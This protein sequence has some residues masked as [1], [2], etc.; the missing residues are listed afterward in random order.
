MND[1]QIIINKLFRDLVK[2]Y[3]SSKTSIIALQAIIDALDHLECSYDELKDQK[4]I[5]SDQIKNTQPRMFPLDNLMILLDKDSVSHFQ[6][7]DIDST[8]NGVKTLFKS[9]LDRLNDDLVKLT[10]QSLKCVE[11]GDLIVIHSIEENVELLIPEAK[12]Q[13]KNFKILILKQD[14]E[15]TGHVIK[16][17]DKYEIDF[18]V[19]PE[20][21]LVHYFEQVNKLF[22]GTQALTLD[23]KLICDPGTSNIVSECHLNNIPVYL[24][25]KSLKLSHFP[26]SEQNIK[27]YETKEHHGGIEYK[28]IFYSND[29]VELKLIDHIIMENGETSIDKIHDFSIH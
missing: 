20:Y 15:T 7:G 28:E 26:A 21:D 24:F 27:K 16:I 1:D 4:R 25:L 29:I 3:S 13:G 17:L 18:Q 22:I 5:L 11:D 6:L 12:K 2:V 8:K 9:Y 23:N 19:I 14:F 10:H